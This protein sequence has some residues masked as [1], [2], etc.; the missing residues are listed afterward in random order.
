MKVWPLGLAALVW[1]SAAL[2]Q[3][4][5][6]DEVLL[7]IGGNSVGYLAPCGCT[8]PMAGG[9]QRRAALIRALAKGK[10]A[11]I[12]ENGSLVGG[13][14]R[15]D[16]LKAE[17]AAQIFKQVGASAIGFGLDEARL[18]RGAA[19]SLQQLSGERFVCTSL[20]PSETN[21][22]KAWTSRHGLITGS[23]DMRSSALGQALG[24]RSL[25]PIAA[26]RRLL[27][28]AKASRARAVLLLQ[29]SFGEAKGL[30]ASVPGFLAIVYQSKG[31]PPATPEKVGSTWLVSPG[32]QGL[33]ELVLTISKGSVTSYRAVDVG[34]QIAEDAD[35]ARIYKDYLLQVS[36]EDLLSRLPRRPT[37]PFAGSAACAPCHT[38][39]H[40]T[41]RASQ[42]AKALDA[43]EKVGHARDP[44]CVGCHVVGINSERGFRSRKDTPALAG[45]GCESC[46]GPGAAHVADPST[47]KMPK[48]G[49]ES[50]NACHRPEH[51]P[52]FVFPR[53]WKTIE[54]K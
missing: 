44:E 24:E 8:K 42:H 6:K 22:L 3:Q 50:C 40:R 2:A 39:A 52:G 20:D 11:V 26:A 36:E 48:A 16:M 33:H 7:L 31:D 5:R 14:G 1:G 13:F 45:V 28:A 46:H 21:E 19:T 37:E 54:H 34:W 32:S 38:S 4:G 23:I 43:L 49:P 27:A 29:G 25:E 12:V 18:P 10:R 41:W 17:A 15:Q 35:A 9:I 30:A 53:F 51:S 47:A